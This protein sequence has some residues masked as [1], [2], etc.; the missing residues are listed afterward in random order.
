[1]NQDQQNYSAFGSYAGGGTSGPALAP[2]SKRFSESMPIPQ[3][4]GLEAYTESLYPAR[5]TAQQ[6]RTR[7]KYANK[8][9]VT[10][11][12]RIPKMA[13]IAHFHAVNETSNR[14]CRIGMRSVHVNLK[15]ETT[16]LRLVLGVIIAK[17]GAVSEMAI[18]KAVC[19]VDVFRKILDV[20]DVVRFAV[21]RRVEELEVDLVADWAGKSAVEI[22]G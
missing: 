18:Q 8:L 16:N 12:G 22:G 4:L 7:R 19:V 1:M 6:E 20:G 17:R 11:R 14:T 15:A 21:P 3:V 5:T 13:V 10:N 9:R 2:V